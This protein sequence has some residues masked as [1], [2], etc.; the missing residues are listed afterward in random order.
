[1][2]PSST[3][4][5]LF[6]ILSV[7]FSIIV[8]TFLI[9]VF[10]RGYRLDTA[11]NG[12]KI[13]ITGLLSATSK[14]R[15]ANIYINNLLTSTTDNT[16]NLNPGNYM[17]KIVK[18]G[19][20]PWIKNIQIQPE[21]VSLTDAQLF[22]ISP[23]LNAITSSGVINPSISPDGNK[24]IYAVA[25]TSA[26]SKENGLY[27]L[28]INEFSLLLGKYTPHLLSLNLPYLDWSKYTF[29]FSPNSRQVIASSKNYSSVYLFSIDQ[30]IDSKNLFDISTKLTEIKNN[31]Q[32]DQ[33]QITTIKLE[34]IPPELVALIATTSST[35]SFNSTED[36]ILYQAKIDGNLDKNIISPPP[37]ISNQTQSRSLK[38]DQFYV[39]DLK[40]DTNFLIGDT[41]I[42]NLSWLPNSNNL[43][44]TQDKNIRVCDYDATN[45][46]TIYTSYL[47]IKDILSSLDGYKI[48]VS[49]SLNAK[50]PQNLYSLTIKER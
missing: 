35:L 17:V 40:E 47:P 26:T 9:S 10:A 3:R 19:F 7:V 31:W 44:F 50:S 21:F 29:E 41:S 49:T 14:P 13:K 37:I 5:S 8:V 46:Q 42:S 2:K 39:Y 24:I 36:K 32:N 22:R 25:S 1:M 27:L 38:K 11:N 4:K 12:F 6:I 34:K 28:E 48:I 33:Q 16:I 15:S 30:N 23:E 45:F 20:Y 43:I 18:E